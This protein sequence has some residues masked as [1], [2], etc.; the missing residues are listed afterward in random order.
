MSKNESWGNEKFVY[1]YCDFENYW[2]ED[3]SHVVLTHFVSGYFD[4]TKKLL[5]SK[6]I[7]DIPNK[8]EL[9]KVF[10]ILFERNKID[11]YDFWSLKLVTKS[12]EVYETKEPLRCTISIDDSE[13]VILDINGDAK[14]FYIAFSVMIGCNVKLEKV[15]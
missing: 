12:G 1:G 5:T 3:L 2:G 11:S 6:E 13:F 7:Y 8:A 15:D 4:I 10:T 14:T 9:K